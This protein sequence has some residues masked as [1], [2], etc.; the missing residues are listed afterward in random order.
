MFD[1]TKQIARRAKSIINNKRNTVSG[2][3]FSQFVEV[4]NIE[5]RIADGFNINGFAVL[6]D[7]SFKIVGIIALINFTLIP[8]RL[9]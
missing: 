7:G 9:N 8:S 2:G 4:G 6:V 5:F 3:D 1:G